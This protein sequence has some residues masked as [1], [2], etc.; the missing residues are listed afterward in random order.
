MKNIIRKSFWHRYQKCT[1]IKAKR[2]TSITTPIRSSG[3]PH[4][5]LLDCKLGRTK[6]DFGAVQAV[7]LAALGIDTVVLIIPTFKRKL[8]FIYYWAVSAY[9]R[10]PRG[11]WL[12][13]L[14]IHIIILVQLAVKYMMLV[15][16]QTTVMTFCPFAVRRRLANST[17]ICSISLFC[18]SS[19]WDSPLR[20]SLLWE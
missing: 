17:W 1:H 13:R 19:I 15:L 4:C 11:M 8:E 2:E 9:P 20:I 10:S 14:T 6:V 16:R 18:F 12:I 5:L 7:G 3:L